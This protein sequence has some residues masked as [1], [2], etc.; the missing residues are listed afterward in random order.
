[1]KAPD[2]TQFSEAVIKKVNGHIN[3]KHCWL[4]PIRQELNDH[5]FLPSVLA[6]RINRDIRAG[7][8]YKHKLKL[9]VHG[10][11]K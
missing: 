10:V 5:D 11:K 2:T 7:K 1:M 3:N 4:V 9:N 8:V 6:M